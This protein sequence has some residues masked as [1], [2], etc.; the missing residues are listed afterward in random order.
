MTSEKQRNESRT[1]RKKRLLRAVTKIYNKERRKPIIVKS[2]SFFILGL[3]GAIFAP[4]YPWWMILVI[5]LVVGV[6]SYKFPY[7]SLIVLS[8]FVT[9]ATAYQSPEFGLIFVI[10]SLI[11]LIPSLFNWKFGFFVFLAIF[12]IPLLL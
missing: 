11:I 8:I 5:A 2:F 12:L 3:F 4:F 7:L 1:E 6:V 9:G 10:F